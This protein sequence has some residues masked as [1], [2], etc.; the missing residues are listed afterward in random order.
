MLRQSGARH[1]LSNR[2]AADIGNL[3]QPIKQAECLKYTSIDA[4]ADA[5]VSGLD[6][7]QSRAG[8]E[9]ALSHDGHRQPPTPTRIVDVGA[10]LAQGALHSSRR[11]MWRRHLG[12]SCYRL[13]GYVARRLQFSQCS[14]GTWLS[15]AVQ[16]K[17]MGEVRLLRE[18]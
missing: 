6:P 9:G 1:R 12:S 2:V 4:D 3:A 8:R 5:G 13:E 17:S 14:K 16:A 10:K 11:M 15:V 7:L 18:I